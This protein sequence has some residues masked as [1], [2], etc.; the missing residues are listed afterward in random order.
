MQE[1]ALLLFDLCE[2]AP[3]AATS[4]NVFCK[5]EFF[6]DNLIHK[7]QFGK[8]ALSG[9]EVVQVSELERPCAAGSG[10]DGVLRQRWQTRRVVPRRVG[11]QSTTCGAWEEVELF[12]FISQTLQEA[13]HRL[14]KYGG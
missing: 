4:D 8:A 3:L 10:W 11:F 7:S 9:S 1:I 2:F 14:S 5:I 6:R 13:Q 12:T